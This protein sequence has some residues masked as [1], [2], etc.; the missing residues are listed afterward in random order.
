MIGGRGAIS[1]GR[2]NDWIA[3]EGQVR[4]FSF[5]NDATLTG[6]N[7]A[8]DGNAGADEIRGDGIASGDF[9]TIALEG[10]DDLVDGGAGDDRIQGDG[11]SLGQ[12]AS[13]AGGNDRLLGGVGDDLLMG[14]G[15]ARATY[16]FGSAVLTGG[17]DR[18][19]GG[20]GVDALYG[21]GLAYSSGEA[22]GAVLVG[23]DDRL[24][25]GAGTDFL[26]GDGQATSETG[27]AELT[28]G[29]DTFVFRL[30]YGRDTV[31][32]FRRGDGDVVELAGTR[33]A[34]GDLDTNGS[35]DLDDEDRFV[36]VVASNTEIDVGRATE[37][38]GSQID[39]LA[40]EG[41]TGLREGDFLFV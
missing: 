28:G 6:G 7:D 13:V 31:L 33:L 34:W 11:E 30:G 29:A 19:S 26:W 23:G 1:G 20:A 12:L 22:A 36:S 14:E 18:L 2:G 32:D 39:V 41:V 16:E 24:V 37:R 10:G 25:G 17:D 21:D 40:F 27:T 38:V 3:G 4:T 8:L 9:A 15:E 35:G 5:F